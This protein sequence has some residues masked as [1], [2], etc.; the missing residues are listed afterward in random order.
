MTTVVLTGLD[1]AQQKQPHVAGTLE[2]DGTALEHPLATTGGFR[3]P[4]QAQLPLLVGIGG[5]RKGTFP[6]NVV[7]V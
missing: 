1:P 7:L 3:Q 6:G 4:P 2:G 5:E